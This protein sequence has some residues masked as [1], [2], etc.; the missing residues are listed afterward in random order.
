MLKKDVVDKTI[1]SMMVARSG[2]DTYVKP[3]A[4]RCYGPG[5]A[6]HTDYCVNTCQVALNNDFLSG[7][8]DSEASGICCWNDCENQ[9]YN[10][11]KFACYCDEEDSESTTTSAPVDSRSLAEKSE[12]TSGD[13][14]NAAAQY[15]LHNDFNVVEGTDANN[16]ADLVGCV[17][18]GNEDV[19]ND[20]AKKQECLDECTKNSD[21]T[22]VV[23]HS[24]G[25]MLKKNVDGKTIDNMM[26]ARSGFETYVKPSAKRCHAEGRPEH[27]DWCEQTCQVALNNDFL[28]GK[29]SSEASG[30]CCWNDCEDQLYNGNKFHCYCDESVDQSKLLI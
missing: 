2:F 29:G 16:Q 17:A 9:T 25:T 27:D 24:K 23:F 14:E 7:H 11:V 3:S 21:C 15:V 4:K 19:R 28:S 13:N 26:V 5:R 18:T 12:D 20:Q 1:D 6:D 22:G 30:I 8:G 10:G